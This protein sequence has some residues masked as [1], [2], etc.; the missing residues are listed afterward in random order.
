MSR[1]KQKSQAINIMSN[2]QYD[3]AIVGAGPAGATAA[4]LLA[5]KQRRVVLID[6]A[7]FP[8][9]VTCAGWLNARSTPL[10]DELPIKPKAI[11]RSIFHDVTFYRPDFSE[12]TKPNFEDIPGYLIDRA[13][14]DNELVAAAKTNDV[15]VKTG[16]TVRDLRLDE[17]SVTL[18]LGEKGKLQSRLLLLAAGRN[19][20][21][22]H[23][24][25][26]AANEEESPIWTA[27]VD[28]PLATKHAPKKSSVDVVLGLDNGGSFGLICMTKKRI[29]IGVHWMG[30]RSHTVPG[31]VLLCRHAAEH[32]A[33]PVDISDQARTA[34]LIRSPA[35]AALNR[36]TH[37]GK[38]TLVIGDAGGFVSAASNEGIYPA[39][40]SAQ[41][42]AEVMDKALYSVHSQDELMT[43]NAQWRI[44][45][46]DYLRSPHTDIQ[47]LLPLIFN[48][49]PM[50][51]RMAAAF[52]LGENI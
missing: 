21:L 48:N 18:D 52:F 11:D 2:E 27:Q 22:L 1:I 13:K 25:G 33:V 28:Q 24:A 14:F 7:E 51:D 42:A 5:K 36:D 9:A 44:Q 45:M 3:V 26:V 29:S 32:K 43:F 30:E 12:S 50:A 20:P 4:I 41:I 15:D 40:W 38:H 34:K 46:A 39:M 8:R 47:F 10:L 17:S 31:L 37:V 35:S 6:R 19:T 49:Q 23:H 16:Y